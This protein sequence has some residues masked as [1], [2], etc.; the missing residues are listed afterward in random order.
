MQFFLLQAIIA[1]K[2][3]IVIIDQESEESYVYA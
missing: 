1:H 3:N 2:P